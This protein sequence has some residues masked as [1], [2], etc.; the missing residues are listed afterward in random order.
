MA[1][2]IKWKGITSYSYS[3]SGGILTVDGSTVYD[4]TNNYSYIANG[5]LIISGDALL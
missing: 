3:A 5:R 2:S 4:Y 1:Y